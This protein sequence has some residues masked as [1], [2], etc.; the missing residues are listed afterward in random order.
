MFRNCMILIIVVLILAMPVC[1]FA[2]RTSIPAVQVSDSPKIDGDISDSCWQQAPK[3]E[4]FCVVPEQT[5]PGEKTEAWICYDQEN[6]Y[7]AFHC[8]ESQPDQIL[9]QQKK[10]GG[11]M[12]GDDQVEFDIDCFN[13]SHQVIWVNVNSIG[14][15]YEHL[16]TG[17]AS[18][19][20]WLG[21]WT[22]AAK[23]TADG[24]DVEIA[25]PFSI[26]QY[27]PKMKSMGILF[28]R[29]H[30][31]TGGKWWTAPYAG[32]NWEPKMFYTWDG[33]S[34]PSYR[35]KPL[36]LAY[37]CLTAGESTASATAGLDAKKS[38]TP[39]LIGTLTVNPD[40]R[41]VEQE[42]IATDF[43]YTEKKQSDLRPFFQEGSQ[44][45]PCSDLF[46]SRRI[47]RLD[48]G[49]SMTGKVGEWNMGLMHAQGTNGDNYDV[50]ALTQYWGGK[51]HI[52]LVA[53]NANTPGT[54]NFAVD[55][56]GNYRFY[57]KNQQT[58][59][60][61]TYFMQADAA[62]GSEHGRKMS[63]GLLERGRPRT[64]G[65][66]IAHDSI[67]PNFDP[68]IGYM[69]EKD[70]D[71]WYIYLWTNDSPAKGKLMQWYVNMNAVLADHLNGEL[72]HND[73]K[74]SADLVFRNNTGMG[75]SWLGSH[76]PPYHDNQSNVYYSW[77][78]RNLYR[79]GSVGYTTGRV[80]GGDY[81]SYNISQGWDLS[82]KLSVN[83]GYNYSRIS[84][85][86][87]K[88]YDAGQLV[89]TVNYD[90]S[91][92]RTISGRLV[93]NYGHSN[94]YFAYSQRV[95]SGMDVYLLFGDPNASSTR[96]TVT[97]KLV[98]PLF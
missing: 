43:S 40:F 73:L 47:D 23:R 5:I 93:N 48:Y 33:L 41:N 50:A 38:F 18:K 77:N 4:D 53:A 81:I 83:L 22:A 9:S 76:R 52:E 87:P 72:F 94:L 51:G 68:A 2:Q 34:L 29:K 92:E 7:V 49:G 88:A 71:C 63:F 3:V 42:V 8:T 85:P 57:D 80:A 70:M 54:D 19:I 62:T 46:Y 44:Y 26:L 65:W 36:A 11:N 30:Q 86:S 60:F 21:D 91:N 61:Y 17:D 69:P 84:E 25:I 98:R 45:F 74:V 64:L 58:I 67:D 96:N 39:E 95:R 28:A 1:V 14:T 32:D 13:N 90:L 27:D 82:K 6:I 15:Q 16:Q 31:R 35:K 66:H 56:G 10:R 37:T 55:I 79:S 24:Y 12:E 78:C 97:L 89:G 59:T 20:E 75:V